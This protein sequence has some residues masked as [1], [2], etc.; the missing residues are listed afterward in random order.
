MPFWKVS[1]S[2]EKMYEYKGENG[3]TLLLIP[4]PGLGVTTANITY[5]VGSR[6]EGLGLK[7]AT[8]YLE[9]GMF[10]GS[11]NFHGKNG[12]WKLEEL[13]MYMNATTYTD[14]TNYFEIMESKYLDEAVMREADR[15]LQPLL[16]QELLDSEM[17]VVRNEF[18][19]GN[20]NDFEI[21]HKRLTATAFMAH[22]YHHSTIG[23]KS[24]IENV[25]AEALQNFH[26]TFYVPNNATYTFVGNFDP[27]YV[28]NL[29]E[30]HFKNIPKGKNI[31]TMYTKEPEQLG[32]RRVLIEKPTQTSLLG[33]GFKSVHGLSK[34][35]IVNKV[36]ALYLTDG[37]DSVME[38]LRKDSNV[39]IHDVM[40]SFERM[41]DPYLFNVW[42]TTNYS[43]RMV[44]ENAEKAVMNKLLNIKA[45]S[46]K[47]LQAIK[48]K[49][50]YGWKDSM[51]TTKGMAS[52]VN[53]SIARGDAFDVF[54]KFKVLESVTPDDVTRVA[55]YLFHPRQSTVVQVLPGE[56]IPKEKSNKNYEKSELK[57]APEF[58]EKPIKKS[59]KFEDNTT[60]EKQHSFTKFDTNKIHLRASLQSETNFSPKEYVTRLM[61]SEILSKGIKL[62][63]QIYNETSVEQFYGKNG[64]QRNF[65]IG[66]YGL[67]IHMSLPK[68]S[69]VNTTIK[70]LKNEIKTPLMSVTDF[71]YLKSK[72]LAELRGSSNSVNTTAKVLLNQKLFKPGTVHYRHSFKDLVTS[73]QNVTYQDVKNEHLKSLTAKSV[74]SILGNKN[75]NFNDVGQNGIIKLKPETL[76]TTNET[77]KHFIPGKTSCT[78][79]MGSHVSP[80]LATQ[81]AV[82]CLGNG[83][84]GKLMKHVRD[85]LGLTYGIEAYVKEKQGTMFITATYSPTLLDRGINET[86]NVLKE[87]KNG[88]TQED[89]DIQKT[90]MKGIRKVRFDNPSNIISTIHAEKLSLNNMNY[91]DNFDDRVDAVTLKEVNEAIQSIDLKKLTTVIVGSFQEDSS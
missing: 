23:W 84:S 41:K 76:E 2:N 49:I 29:V 35:A 5:H 17:T 61:L 9:H 12:M 68:E 54:D 20:N 19:R 79:L 56:K 13:G 70:L 88:V 50:K 85:E 59:I 37:A 66:D 39:N 22:P 74:V 63:R 10:K 8:H 7:G 83:F 25:S 31:P 14:R 69:S 34:D 48:N 75:I 58:L 51:E 47:Q 89:I 67:R 82:N 81:I 57:V 24:D 26:K 62:N 32:Q 71:N 44:L 60:S 65:S 30:K 3:L 33:I 77:I 4:R 64:I 1:R 15:M 21:A 40:A 55:K 90:I 53:E 11:K 18:E 91:I 28:K 38:A 27:E 45:P 6:N 46:N 16:T 78:V 52:E 72:L 73:L 42:V 36:L 43:S 80:N 86:H 87:W